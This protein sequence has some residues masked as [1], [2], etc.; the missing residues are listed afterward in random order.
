[1]FHTHVDAK[2]ADAGYHEGATFYE[3]KAFA[4]ACRAPCGLAVA[5]VTL[6]DGLAAVAIGV[7]A[8]RSLKEGRPVLLAEVL[9]ERGDSS[10]AAAERDPGAPVADGS[11]S[12][13]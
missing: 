9:A 3:L 13:R 1:M 12:G 4:D 6:A 7:A 8:E 10:G 5:A 2:L 11:G